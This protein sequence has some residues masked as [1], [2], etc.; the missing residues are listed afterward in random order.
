MSSSPTN[1]PFALWLIIPVK[2]F[3]EGKSRLAAL[4][5]PELRAELSQ[6]WL[7]HVLTTAVSWGHFAG[8]AVISR[9]DA[10]L[11]VASELGAM[12]IVERGDDLNAALTQACE[13][14]TAASAEAVLA[15]P[16]DL[17]LLTGA[18]LDEL[19]AQALLGEG[20]VLA[21]SR[22]GGTNAL[23]TRPPQAVPYAFGVA[24]ANRHRALAAAA[25]LRCLVYHSPTLALD[26][27]HPEDL[28]LV[29]E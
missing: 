29:S 16:S 2:P 28:L 4:L 24:S 27:D 21:P 20:V 7:T 11:A 19:Y 13:V 1:T 5:S 12:P 18:D 8:I 3:G 10:V 17:P 25:G 26:I 9:A 23:L 15:L 14:V 6:R 22:D